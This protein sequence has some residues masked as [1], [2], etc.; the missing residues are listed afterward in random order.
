MSI[1]RTTNR[2]KLIVMC[3]AIGAYLVLWVLTQMLGSPLV[4]NIARMAERNRLGSAYSEEPM[5]ARALGPFIVAVDRLI[6]F[7]F[8][9][10]AS[11]RL[12]VRTFRTT[13]LYLW[14]GTSLRLAEGLWESEVKTPQKCATVEK[15]PGGSL[16][17]DSA[18]PA[19]EQ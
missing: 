3:A 4:L 9:D 8:Q 12:A 5:Y 1:S 7:E 11:E 10:R 15:G 14:I 2:R 16:P 17:S 13:S 19:S 6:T 18:V